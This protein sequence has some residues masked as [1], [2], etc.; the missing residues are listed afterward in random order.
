MNYFPVHGACVQFYTSLLR[1][2]SFI[3]L[4]A[5]TVKHVWFLTMSHSGR[6]SLQTYYIWLAKIKSCEIAYNANYFQI[7]FRN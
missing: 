7:G 5:V 3:P 4:A 2:T 6:Q 1:D